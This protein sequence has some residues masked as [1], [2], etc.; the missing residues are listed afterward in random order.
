MPETFGRFLALL[1]CALALLTPHAAAAQVSGPAASDVTT[2]RLL[3]YIAV[4]HREAVHDGR[5]VNA[6]EYAEM[7]EFARTARTNLE[8]LPAKTAKQRVV[9]QACKLE[10]SITATRPP[11]RLPPRARTLSCTQFDLQ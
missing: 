4:D 9:S 1:V 8:A 7:R 6:A 10:Q 2:W 3:D 11:R 5:V